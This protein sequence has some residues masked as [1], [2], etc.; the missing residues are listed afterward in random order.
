MKQQLAHLRDRFWRGILR[1]LSF[2]SKELI[3]IRH[4]PQL[5]LV[6]I[7]APFIV[8]LLFGLGFSS[9]A[10]PLETVLVVPEGSGLSTRVEDYEEDFVYPLVLQEVSTDRAA[11][12]RRL[13]ERELDV[14]IVMPEG[15]FET[16]S[17][18]QQAEID[19]LYNE[20]APWQ[21]DLLQFYS[22]VQT[23]E[24]NRRVLSDALQDTS[25]QSNSQFEELNEYPAEMD[26]L[27]RQFRSQLEQGD[28]QAA[29]ETLDEMQTETRTTSDE[30]VQL[31]RFLIATALS[32]G[33]VGAPESPPVQ[34]LEAAEHRLGEINTGLTNIEYKVSQDDAGLNEV[35]SDLEFVN[36]NKQEFSEIAAELPAIPVDVL[37][38]PFDAE[39][40]NLAPTSPGFVDFY[41][42]AVLAL[43]IQHIAVTLTAL[44]LVRERIQGAI[45]M[46]Q[47]SP[48]SAGELL[49]G[50]Y[51]A[52][53]I[54]GVFLTAILVATL[55]VALGTPMLGPWGYLV[56]L[57]AFLLAASLG[58]GFM[59]S[60]AVRTD[61]QAIQA[62]ML[63][64]LASVFFS[65][66]FL[67]LDNLTTWVKVVS[68]ALPVTYGIEGLQ[69]LML[70]GE[71]PPGW[72]F[73]VLGGMAVAFALLAGFFLRQQFRRR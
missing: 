23:S 38:S 58:F 19:L 8:L 53:F 2:F 22:R 13:Q 34:N 66:F 59:I 10:A 62:A 25:E 50:K 72:V 44:A 67:P 73:A 30:T 60:A 20:L 12:V 52:Y 29:L 54:Q 17:S 68:Y 61:A 3:Q 48:L 51:I 42:P 55:V 41:S 14:V 64:M 9:R 27:E 18:G 35:E 16:I 32:V 49:T 57:L 47:V 63:L 6:L 56:L 4:Q 28:R 7:V 43:L 21:R 15:A 24:L 70:R 5:I 40:I 11:A 65:G 69:E 37:V 36:E 26:E 46:F 31:Q 1:P 71:I 39:E 33:A 45:E